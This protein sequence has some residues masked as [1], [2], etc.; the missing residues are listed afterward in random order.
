MQVS[1]RDD[2]PPLFLYT[3]KTAMRRRPSSGTR[4]YY[5]G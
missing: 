5:F 4:E 2:L 1:A 3:A